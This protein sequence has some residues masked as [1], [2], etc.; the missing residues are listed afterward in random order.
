MAGE[1]ADARRLRM[2]AGQHPA[3]VLDGNRFSGP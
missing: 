1:R 3:R 2:K